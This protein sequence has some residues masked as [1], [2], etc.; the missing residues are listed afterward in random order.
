MSDRFRIIFGVMDQHQHFDAR[1][2]CN[3]QENQA[4]KR[5]ES[6]AVCCDTALQ[7][8]PQN[9]IVFTHA[10]KQERNSVRALLVGRRR[11]I[12]DTW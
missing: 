12:D 8:N 2:L 3:G 9:G 1:I 4:R 7:A 5:C 11:F 6:G 10:T